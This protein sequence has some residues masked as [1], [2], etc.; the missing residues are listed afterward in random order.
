MQETSR[1]GSVLVVVGWVVLA[2]T[3]LVGFFVFQ[4]AREGNW[5]WPVWTAVQGTLG[6]GLIVAGS[7]YRRKASA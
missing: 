5:F 2:A 6:L 1:L 7:R 4:D 3:A